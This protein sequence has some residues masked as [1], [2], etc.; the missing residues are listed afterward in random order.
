MN[1]DGS[2]STTAEIDSTTPNGP[3]LNGG[4]G[5]G[6]SVAN[7]GDLNGDGVQD[8]AVGARDDAALYIHFMN[9]DGSISTTTK[10]DSTTPNGPVLNGGDE[11]GFSVA[12]IG[13][14][15]G[16]GVQDIAVGAYNN[17]PFFSGGFHI[18]Y[19]KPLGATISGSLY[20]N[21]GSYFGNQRG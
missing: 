18:H 2:I 16:D 15:D 8:L 1:A 5:Y 11:Y 4:D 7:I 9:T 21:E 13:D 17:H 10:I 14:L 12:N 20:S 3:V 19:L 6:S